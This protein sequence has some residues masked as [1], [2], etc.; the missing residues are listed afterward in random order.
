M[1]SVNIENTD[2]LLS[3]LGS[4]ISIL[5]CQPDIYDYLYEHIPNAV[6]LSDRLWRSWEGDMPSRYISPQVAGELLGKAGL[7]P[8]KEI[9]VYSSSGGF[10]HQGDGLEATM[11]TYTLARWGFANI[12]L[13]NG[14]LDLW[15]S[16]QKPLTKEFPKKEQTTARLK[17]QNDYFLTHQQFL[18]AREEKNAIVVDVR[19]PAAYEKSGLW[20]KTGHI[21][22]AVNIPWKVFTEH[23][24]PYSYRAREHIEEIVQARGASAEKSII[25]YCGT[26]REATNSFVCFKWLLGYPEV[27][28]YEGSFTE[29]CLLN[30]ETVSGKSPW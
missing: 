11:T 15:K 30:N 24:N 29:W 21:P 16:Q 18:E 7:N 1:N 8:E 23:D 6:Y 19:P 2:W 22:G 26:G 10:S 9:A 5:D 12:H 14:G 25:L 20:S 13:I 4:D 17:V 28:I 3:R 27:K